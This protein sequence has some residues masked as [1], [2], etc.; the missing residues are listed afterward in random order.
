MNAPANALAQDARKRVLFVDHATALAGGEI[1]LL[2]LLEHLDRAQWE[3]HL[4][5]FGGPLADRAAAQG[6]PVH[7]APLPRLRRSWRAPVD[8]AAGARTLARIVRHTGADIL[9]AFSVRA[10]IYAAPAALLTRTPYVWYRNDF[11]LGESE[12]RCAWLERAGKALYCTL[13]A[14]VVANSQATAQQQPCG[15]KI[16]V[17]HNGIR[18]QRFDPGMDGNVFR[19]EHGIPQDAL[20]LGIVGR[21]NPIKGQDRFLRVLAH[22]LE[23]APDAWGLV[24]G[25]AIFGEDAYADG[26]LALAK[27]LGVAERVTFTG[28]LADPAL[29]LAAMDLFVQPCDPE[30][31]GLVNLEAMAMGKAVVGYAQGSL[32]EIVVDGET[33][34][35]APPG[36]EEAL[37]RATSALLHDPA[38]RAAWGRAGRARAEACFD[39]R[40]MARQVSEVLQRA[41]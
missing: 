24:V 20:V 4:A 26:L 6:I 5:C 23:N 36:D 41:V 15:H 39:I 13:A 7:L 17:V 31:L 12:P 2:M 8:L 30:A 35:L 28:Q 32:P 16:T 33:G 22:V 37:A 18:V 38:L 21:L 27:E 3:P 25:G 19:Q 11:W 34:R 14:H 40:R 10:V 1:S 9:V 29:A